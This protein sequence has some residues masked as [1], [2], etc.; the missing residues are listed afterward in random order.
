MKVGLI[1]IG[2]RLLNEKIMQAFQHGDENIYFKNM[3]RYLSLG[4]TYEATKDKLGFAIIRYPKELKQSEA[5][6]KTIEKWQ[7]E[8]VIALQFEKRRRAAN[9]FKASRDLLKDIGTIKRLSEGLSY[10]EKRAFL[11]FIFDNLE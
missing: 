6:S 2:K 3:T 9:K 4:A 7:G 10:S 5:D 1:Y 11:E 8:E